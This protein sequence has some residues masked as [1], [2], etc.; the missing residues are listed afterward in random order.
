M[1]NPCH[2]GPIALDRAPDEPYAI[3]V[4]HPSQISSHSNT[5]A[6]RKRRSASFGN[7]SLPS[8][9]RPCI[10]AYGRRTPCLPESTLSAVPVT[11]PAAVRK[12]PLAELARRRLDVG[13]HRIVPAIQKAVKAHRGQ[14]LDDLLVAP[15]FLELAH[16]V[17]VDAVGHAA[18]GQR[19]IQRG[20]LGVAVEIAGP[21]FPD[22][23][24]LV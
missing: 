24:E 10:W 18:G 9:F 11:G 21:I 8:G 1:Q 16:D 23:I 5:P 6:P 22:G 14:H 15:V 12:K 17:V 19:E 3:R 20:T 4:A 13:R 7:R 2:T